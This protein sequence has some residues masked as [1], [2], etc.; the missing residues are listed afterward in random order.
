MAHKLKIQYDIRATLATA[1]RNWR[2]ENNVPLKQVAMDLGV[3]IATVNTWESGKR[4]PSGRH[5]EML[6]GY[7]GLP[8]CR[9]FCVVKDK[10]VPQECMQA[11]PRK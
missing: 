8:P 4:F 10:C 3:S 9:L 6:V 1:F 11:L 7:L 2:F 5:F